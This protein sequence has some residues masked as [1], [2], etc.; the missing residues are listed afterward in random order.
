MS[1][2]GLAVPGNGGPVAPLRRIIAVDPGKATG[3]AM[4]FPEMPDQHPNF[5]CGEM[6]WYD[7]IDWYNW[8]VQTQAQ[9]ED[10][11]TVVES[12]TVTMETLK[13]TRQY[14]SLES[15]GAMRYLSQ[16]HLHKEIVLQ[17]PAVGK[18]FGTRDKLEKIGW[19]KPGSDDAQDA[20]RHLLTYCAANDMVD[21]S[22]LL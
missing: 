13:K 3:W 22:Q 18:R 5:E 21:L 12:Y 7:W 1:Y 16:R 15:I 4:Y 8:F 20:A 19:W 11:T 17:A 2:P 14:W 10:V 9:T 6:T